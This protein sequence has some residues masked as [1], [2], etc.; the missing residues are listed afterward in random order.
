LRSKIYFVLVVLGL[1]LGVASPLPIWP[2]PEF[3]R[4]LLPGMVSAALIISACL[5]SMRRGSRSVGVIAMIYGALATL[6][7]LA[8]TAAS[9]IASMTVRPIE[10]AHIAIMAGLLPISI[11]V[12]IV[13]VSAILLGYKTFRAAKPKD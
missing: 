2:G 5:G 7:G 9:I 1:L 11:G 12:L 8:F 6:A 10:E 13:G 3:I 4:H